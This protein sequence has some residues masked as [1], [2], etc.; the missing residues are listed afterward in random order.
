MFVLI[1]C[2]LNRKRK[3]R[4]RKERE[5]KKEKRERDPIPRYLDTYF[6]TLSP[7][8]QYIN[9]TIHIAIDFTR[10]THLIGSI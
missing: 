3:K 8:T 1:C 6:I 7:S 4:E 2:V 5:R 9:E 10:L